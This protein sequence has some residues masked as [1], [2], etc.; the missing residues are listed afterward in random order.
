MKFDKKIALPKS[1]TDYFRNRFIL[2]LL[3]LSLGIGISYAVP[4]VSLSQSYV[5]SYQAT[6]CPALGNGYTAVELTNSTVGIRSIAKKSTKL[7]THHSLLQVVSAAPLFVDSTFGSSYTLS[8]QGG[9]GGVA[10]TLCEPGSADQWFVGGSGSITSAGVLDIVNSGLSGSSV[11]IHPY[12]SKNALPPVLVKIPANS[13]RKVRLDT[14]VAGDDLMALEVITR[15]GR[16]TSFMYDSRKKG[17]RSLGM[18]YVAAGRGPSKHQVI[19]IGLNPSRAHGKVKNSLR[20]L[21]PGQ[22]DA[23]VSVRIASADG[24]FT[25]LGFDS[26][27]I[28]RGK[29]LDIQ[30]ANLISTSAFSVIIDAD[31]PLV[32]GLFS[33]NNLDFAWGSTAEPFTR[34]ALNFAGLTPSFTFTG[35]KFTVDVQMVLS[36]GKKVSKSLHGDS[37]LAWSPGAPLKTISF[38]SQGKS[39]LYGGTLIAS[40]NGFT[41]LPLQSNTTPTQTLLPITDVHTLT[42]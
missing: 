23:T 27:V 12:S 19:P 9:G 41:Y 30:L 25:P 14:L 18:D 22:L 17:L 5:G 38:T 15:A 33:Q 1:L 28:Q 4:H 13:D 20:L 32:A 11:E 6:S 29:V 24:E 39:P 10:S 36:S 40:P 34:M 37:F 42:H 8:S 21:V 2:S 35:N 7:N 16:V 31:Q 26:K 3:A